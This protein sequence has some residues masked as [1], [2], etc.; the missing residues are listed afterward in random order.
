[1]TPLTI[2]Y[3]ALVGH[4]PSHVNTSTVFLH[5]DRRT[6]TVFLV[7][8]HMS[9]LSSTERFGRLGGR[10]G[11]G[12]GLTGTGRV[13]T[14]GDVISRGGA[15]VTRLL[16]LFVCGSPITTT[17]MMLLRVR[18][19]RRLLREVRRRSCTRKGWGSAETDVTTTMAANTGN[20]WRTRRRLM[21]DFWFFWRVDW[22]WR[23]ELVDELFS[24]VLA[25]Q[26]CR[27]VLGDKENKTRDQVRIELTKAWL[28]FVKTKP[29]LWGVS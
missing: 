20:M 6:V 21:V 26:G 7:G 18:F 8:R 12:V 10:S 16:L 1:M 14:G 25:M 19:V 27:S 13:V 28:S 17:G 29:Q 23:D 22:F 2:L 3:S 15:G 11:S 24:S 5:F 9:P 4:K